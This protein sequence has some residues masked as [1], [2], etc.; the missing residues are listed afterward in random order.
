MIRGII[1]PDSKTARCNGRI[2]F[3]VL[4]F[5]VTVL[6]LLTACTEPADSGGETPLNPA[7]A[8]D[9]ES[10]PENADGGIQAPGGPVNA[11]SF[12]ATGDAEGALESDGSDLILTGG[13]LDHNK[14]GMSFTRGQITDKDL[15]QVRL[16]TATGVQAGETGTFEVSELS[17]YNGQ[18]EPEN[19]PTKVNI[20]VPDVYEGTGVLTLTQHVPGG[21]NGRMAGIV[22]GIVKQSGGDRE[23]A[24]KAS[25]DINIGC[26]RL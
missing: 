13:C 3:S 14:I 18:V 8:N 10:P 20:L 6:L 26:N 1:L 25:F 12:V 15:F 4:A 9:P 22:E 7:A 5:P 24:I 16:R 19:L 23:A 11:L 17:W 2:R 21:L